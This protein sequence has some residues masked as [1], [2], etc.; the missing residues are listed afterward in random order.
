MKILGHATYVG[1]TGYNSHCKN[2]FRFLSKLHE[3]KIRNFTVGKN[4][5]GL[6]SSEPHGEDVT[7]LDKNLIIQQTLWDNGAL[8]DF[9]IYSGS[10]NYLHD[11]NIVLTEANHY[12]FYH[13]YNGPKIAY[14]VWESTEYYK[15]FLDKLKEYDQ[16]WVAS[17]WQ[18]KITIDQGVSPEKVKV[19]PEGVD[20]SIF[21]PETNKVK[22]EKFRFLI[23]GRWE[24]RKSTKEIIQ[25]FKNV[26]GNNK[27]VELVI[28]VENKFS[29][30][31][32]GSTKNRLKYYNLESDNIISLDFVKKEEYV[33]LLKTGDVF[34]SCSRSEGWNLPLIEA[35]SCGI[36]SLYSN[37]SGQLEF[38]EN[39]GIP[40]KILGEVPCKLFYKENE[41][42]QGN[43]Y[44]PD[45]KDLEKK[46]LEVFNNYQFYKNKALKESEEIRQKFSW[47]NAAKIAS[48]I[49][50]NFSL[51]NSQ[52]E[53]YEEIFNKNT[54]ESFH[55]S[56][57]EN[58][59]VVLDLGCSKG[60]FYFKHKNKNI[61]YYGLDASS[62]CIKDFYTILGT[63][64][65]PIVINALLDNQKTVKLI[66][67]FFHKTDSKLVATLSFK[68]LM[69]LIPDKINFLKFD[70]EGAEKEFLEDD[71]SYKLFKE[72]VEKFSGEIHMSG[73]IISRN[74][75]YDMIRKL[76]NDPEIYCKLYSCDSVDIDFCFWSNPDR[77][78]QIIVSGVIK[79]NSRHENFQFKP[80]S[81]NQEVAL[82]II[83][84]SPSL[85]DII[86]WMPMI[87]KFQK[88]K[89][90][91]VNLYTPYAELFQSTYPNI[92]FDYYRSDINKLN[93]PIRIGA[94]D[95]DGKKWKIGRAHV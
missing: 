16:V 9:N 87:D 1:D 26:F 34:L 81:H 40:I 44:E 24:E 84:E 46:I 90:R 35:M 15:P 75:A 56:Q 82:N 54:Y 25:A 51:K 70:I 22:K 65:D 63:E 39:K 76:Q 18:A 10:N 29:K 88:Q 37:C 3:V 12:Y 7:E 5:K 85:G 49:L 74:Q 92:N 4:W 94:Y 27:D 33:N 58:H 86:A 93:N 30:D 23:F 13:N 71:D 68:N 72:K 55:R 48:S 41:I 52:P 36:P 95:V 31:G 14:T 45:F 8:K 91:I 38:A 43:W 21:F 32:L 57:V 11:L 42:C 62:E 61:K 83:N 20:S 73:G 66:K 69:K 67:P 17:K 64:D 80:S 78:H 50:E 59:D 53:V 47:E 89:N 28:S 6:G 79:K 77:F 19:V 60:F 2:F